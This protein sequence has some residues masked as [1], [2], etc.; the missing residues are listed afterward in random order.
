M[1]AVALPQP[2]LLQWSEACADAQPPQCRAGTWRGRGCEV[3]GRQG[4]LMTEP[5]GKMMRRKA[6][7]GLWRKSLGYA[8]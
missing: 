2:P 6:N 3:V 1:E 4:A 8:V 7:G 5:P